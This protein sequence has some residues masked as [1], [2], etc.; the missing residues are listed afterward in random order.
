MEI[1]TGTNFGVAVLTCLYMCLL[2]CPT[3]TAKCRGRWAI[4]ACYGGNGKRSDPNFRSASQRDTPTLLQKLLLSDATRINQLIQESE[5]S[6]LPLEVVE[7]SP[8]FE[9][10]PSVLQSLPLVD[11]SL[12]QDTPLRKL[13]RYMMALKMQHQL[14]DDADRLI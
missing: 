2:T 11:S 5:E 8:G 10:E 7:S 4:H 9:L 14:R 6:D 13:R 3:V 1:S 12:E